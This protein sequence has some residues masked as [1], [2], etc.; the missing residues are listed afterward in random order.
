[1]LP[2]NRTHPASS[3]SWGCD[4]CAKLCQIV[5]ESN[6]G[7]VQQV[8]ENRTD[9]L[10][11]YTCEQL[12]EPDDIGLALPFY[13]VYY[14]QPDIIEYLFRRGIDLSKPCDPMMFGNPMF[15]AVN[16]RRHRLISVL[17]YCGCSVKKPCERFKRTAIDHATRLNDQEMLET[18]KFLSG[19]EVRA[20]NMFM[21]HFLRRKARR[22][23]L[24][25]REAVIRVQSMLRAIRVCNKLGLARMRRKRA[26]EATESKEQGDI[27]NEKTD[28]YESDEQSL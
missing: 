5:M 15:Y 7:M 4:A 21:K 27:D 2:L 26:A 8:I 22:Q 6:Y 17:D 19:K 12:L 18:M 9:L 13:A 14:D 20:Y 1:M 3:E 23:Y 24:A 25:S 11:L 28:L 16:L 10:D